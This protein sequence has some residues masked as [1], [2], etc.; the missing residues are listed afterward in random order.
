MVEEF[1]APV[2]RLDYVSGDRFDLMWHRHTGAWHC[3]GE[4]LSLAEAL[5]RVANEPYFFFG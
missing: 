3:V 5:D 2:A 1:D 4:H